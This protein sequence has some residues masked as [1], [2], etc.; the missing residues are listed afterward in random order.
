MRSPVITVLCS[1]LSVFSR[2]VSA[3]TVIVSDV[4]PTCKLK[5][6]R[7]VL[8]TCTS[9]FACSSFLNPGASTETL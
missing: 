7:L 3:L 8:A 5:S 2:E 1:P 9:M 4:V 6:T